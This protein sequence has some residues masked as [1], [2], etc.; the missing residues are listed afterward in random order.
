MTIQDISVHQHYK[1]RISLLLSASAVYVHDC[2]IFR[3]EWESDRP[4]IIMLV[5]IISLIND[6]LTSEF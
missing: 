1:S 2:Q 3:I 5:A 6:R 4:S